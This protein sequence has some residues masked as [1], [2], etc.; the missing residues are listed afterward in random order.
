[1]GREIKW[2]YEIGQVIKDEKRYFKIIEKE[3]RCRQRKT[4]KENQK[5]YKCKCNICSG[6]IFLES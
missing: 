1:M 3:I 4:H 6:E 5:W 2:K